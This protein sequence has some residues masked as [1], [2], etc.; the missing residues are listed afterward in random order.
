MYPSPTFSLVA[1]S[2]ACVAVCL[3]AL[4]L[5]RR[6]GASP[7]SPGDL[8]LVQGAPADVRDFASLPVLE[9][10]LELREPMLFVSHI[11]GQQVL[12]YLADVSRASNWERWLCCPLQ[13]HVLGA[14]KN[15][16]MPLRDALGASPLWVLERDGRGQLA[17]AW[18]VESLEHVPEGCKPYEGVMLQEEQRTALE[19]AELVEHGTSGLQGLSENPPPRKSL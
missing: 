13:D 5:W 16:R 1:S 6:F 3:L 19:C 9:T 10:L 4:A 8:W 15:N 7:A 18:L 17:R 14:L 11:K 2:V 12:V